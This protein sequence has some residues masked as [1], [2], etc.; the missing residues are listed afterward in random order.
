[1]NGFSLIV[2]SNYCQV[3]QTRGLLKLLLIRG[4][5]RTVFNYGIGILIAVY[6]FKY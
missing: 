5:K 2:A 3:M 1:M 6:L 4:T